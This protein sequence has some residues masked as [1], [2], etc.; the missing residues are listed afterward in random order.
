ME[1]L[2]LV[3]EKA[4]KMIAPYKAT[5]N[6]YVVLTALTD[7]FIEHGFSLEQ[8]LILSLKAYEL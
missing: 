5:E 6:K 1:S 3:I 8:S 2:N 4:A 7:L